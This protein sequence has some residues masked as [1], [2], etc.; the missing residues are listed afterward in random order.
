MLIALPINLLCPRTLRPLKLQHSDFA[1]NILHK[2]ID[3]LFHA[4][5]E[6]YS[7]VSCLASRLLSRCTEFNC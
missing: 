3:K 5:L 7:R 2:E 4:E 1:R 6:L